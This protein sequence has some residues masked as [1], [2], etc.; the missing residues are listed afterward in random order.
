[1]N[2]L[3]IKKEFILQISILLSCLIILAFQFPITSGYAQ[4]VLCGGEPK[5][6]RLNNPI[7][8]T[9]ARG[10]EVA[11]VVFDTPN[12]TDFQIISNAVREWNAYSLTNCSGVTFKAAVRANRPYDPDEPIPNNTIFIPRVN[13]T[14]VFPEFRNEGTPLQSERAA[15]IQLGPSYVLIQLSRQ[16]R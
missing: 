16:M 6:T 9:W 8:W 12:N 10:T 11:V 3:Q 5:H 15:L 13:P 14:Q 4:Q 2:R 1:M 7:R